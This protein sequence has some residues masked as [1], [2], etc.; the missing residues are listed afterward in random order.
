MD[1]VSF[2]IL[3]QM[4]GIGYSKFTCSNISLK[5]T[6]PYVSAML[7]DGKTG[8]DH[9]N[10]GKIGQIGGCAADFRG[11]DHVTK[12]KIKYVRGQLLQ[13]QLAIQ[14]DGLWR[15][16]FLSREKSVVDMMPTTGYLG[17]TSFTGE[18]MDNHDIIRVKA[19]AIVN[20]HTYTG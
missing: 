18:V 9:D 13:V 8:Y 5:H 12:A 7:G 16:C 14:K 2:S 1:W 17:F 4:V 6:F 19:N 15:D 3:I 20:P 10:D 11:W